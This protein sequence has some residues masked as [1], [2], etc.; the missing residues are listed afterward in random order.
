MTTA[1]RNHTPSP[2]A[3]PMGSTVPD[4]LP[5]RFSATRRTIQLSALV[6]ALA[7]CDAEEESSAPTVTF[8]SN[9]T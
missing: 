1:T 4:G 8:D 6:F 3:A 5:R 2:T 9:T 7:A